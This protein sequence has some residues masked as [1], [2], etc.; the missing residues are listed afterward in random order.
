MMSGMLKDCILPGVCSTIPPSIWGAL[1]RVNPAVAYYHV[2]SDEQ[3]PHVKHLYSFRNVA[4]FKRD[5]ETFCRVF[6]TISL[7]QLLDCLKRGTSIPHNSFLLT[8]DDGF[9]EI[10]H[11]IA[12]ILRE[13]GMPATFFLTSACLDNR[14]MAHHNK[15]SILVD[16][17]QN[18]ATEPARRETCRLLDQYGTDDSHL[19]QRILAI[20]HSQ[21]QLVERI[22]Q[23]LDVNFDAFL[24]ARQPYLSSAEVRDLIKMGFS[25][26]G[27]SL[28]HPMYPALSLNEQLHQTVE[29]V[30]FVCERFELNYRAFAFPHG[31]RNVSELFFSELHRGG[32][33]DISFGTGGIARETMASHFQRFSMENSSA[34][35]KRIIARSYV[36]SLYKGLARRRAHVP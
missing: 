23:V 21:D 20:E 31:D 18:R 6:T 14:A 19:E 15:L 36:R 8:F 3:L 33:V 30:R 32:N 25:I 7:H 11:I 9:S 26:G 13:K 34:P 29:S 16:V 1:T 5:I 2:V 27:H 17:V 12:P 4:Q 28:D 22:A 24:S 10:Y 35:A